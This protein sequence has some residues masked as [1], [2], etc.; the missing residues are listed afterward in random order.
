MVESKEPTHTGYRTVPQAVQRGASIVING[1]SVPAGI[2]PD[3]T[4]IGGYAL[5]HN[6]DRAFMEEWSS[7]NNDQ[8]MVKNSLLFIAGDVKEASAHCRENSTLKSGL[9]PTNPTVLSKVGESAANG[10]R[11][12]IEAFEKKDED[13]EL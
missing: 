1:C 11:L 12:K 10:K 5:T 3:K 8:D 4:L 13:F 7:Q 2:A 9:E 6:I